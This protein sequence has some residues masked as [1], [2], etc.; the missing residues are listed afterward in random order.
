MSETEHPP[1]AD[2]IVFLV[3]VDNTLL[4]NDRFADELSV[5]LEQSSGRAARDRYWELYGQRRSRLGYAD[6]LGALE[7]FRGGQVAG[8]ELLTLSAYLLD[9]PFA[10]LLYPHALDAIKRLCTLGTTVVLSDGDVVFQ[11]RKVQRAGLSDAVSDKVLICLH[12]ELALEVVQSTYPANHYVAVDD[13]PLLLATMKRAMGRRLTTVFVRQG[14]YALDAAG[15]AV[16]PRPD[17]TVGAIGEL[18]A[19]D[20]AVF[21]I[22]AQKAS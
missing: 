15:A 19:L 8:P 3:D 5:R 7:D 13:K 2:R 1:L 6:Y 4:D 12:K 22:G 17:V 18:V 9:Y 16:L 21:V 10:R 20:P 11:P 14:H